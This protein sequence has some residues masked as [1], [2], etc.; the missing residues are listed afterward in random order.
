M[1]N[2]WSSR[3]TFFKPLRTNSHYLAF[4]ETITFYH[5]Y[6]REVKTDPSTGESYIEA[7][8]EDIEWANILLKDVLLAKADELSGECRRF[9]ENLKGWLKAGNKASFYKN[10]IREAFR[11]NPNNLKYYLSQLLRYN[12]LKIAGGNRH[13]SGYE[14]EVTNTE[15]YRQLNQI[16]DN[17]LDA[18]LTNIKNKLAVGNVNNRRV[19]ESVTHSTY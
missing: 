1:R 6:Q 11:M 4:I 15:E 8:L 13:K 19:I 5:Q 16:L 10:E 3:N 2:T 7:T 9:F 17:A 18:A 12:Y 14:Y